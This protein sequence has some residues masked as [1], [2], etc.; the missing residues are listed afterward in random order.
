VNVDL[1]EGKTHCQKGTADFIRSSIQYARRITA[2]PLLVRMDAGN[3]SR[4]N[5]EVCLQEKANFIIKHN[6]RREKPES[7]LAIAQLKGAKREDREG[8][9]VWTGSILTTE[10]GLEKPVRLVFHVVEETI[11]SK[12]QMLLVPN[13]E[14]ATYWTLL[15]CSPEDLI[16]LYRDHAT[17]EQFHSELKTDLDLER[18]PSGKFATNQLVLHA[19]VVAYN[20][21]RLIGQVSLQSPDTPIKKVAQRRRIRTVIQNMIYLA[22]RLVSHARQIKLRFGKHCPWLPSVKR[23]YSAFT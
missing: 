19:G 6:L 5:L 20:I 12:G 11:D 9:T 2:K 18:L 8:K 14:V 22:A 17:S 7:W 13:I 10:H 16:Q 23:I 3:D 21:L 1:R 4:D 15:T